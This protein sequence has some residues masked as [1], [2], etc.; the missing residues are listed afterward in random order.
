MA[1]DAHVSVQSPSPWRFTNGTLA[2]QPSV[3]SAQMMTRPMSRAVTRERNNSP[4]E[5][6]WASVVSSVPRPSSPA[7]RP[8]PPMIA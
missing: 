4:R 3:F 8:V 1:N 6:G 7:K 2:I 5:I